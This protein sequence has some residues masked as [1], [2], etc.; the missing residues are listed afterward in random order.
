MNENFPFFNK[1]TFIWEHL[2]S[3]ESFWCLIEFGKNFQ[4]KGIK[5][6]F[7]Q[8]KVVLESLEA[9]RQI[10]CL[11]GFVFIIWIVFCCLVR[12]CLYTI[13]L[14][15]LS[16]FRRICGFERSDCKNRTKISRSRTL[17]I[18]KLFLHI[19]RLSV[20]R[21]G[22]GSGLN[23]S[24]HWIRTKTVEI[25]GYGWFQAHRGRF[26]HRLTGLS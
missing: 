4:K 23:G 16:Q 10:F 9:F 26:S 18:S 22:E 20:K 12:N 3:T 15:N 19:A 6:V 11:W 2:N 21:E 25:N 13:F 17:I 5:E 24:T 1:L 7:Q 14:R 8:T